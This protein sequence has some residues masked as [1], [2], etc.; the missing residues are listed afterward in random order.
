MHAVEQV[1]QEAPAVHGI[2]GRHSLQLEKSSVAVVENTNLE[3]R[4]SHSGQPKEGLV[5]NANLGTEPEVEEFAAHRN[6]GTY[7]LQLVLSQEVPV[8]YES[9]ETRS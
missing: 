7:F 6:L 5:R 3:T 8:E 9:P 2:L 4:V 1:E